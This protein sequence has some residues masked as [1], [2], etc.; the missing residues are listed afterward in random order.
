MFVRSVISE[1][2][3]NN[4]LENLNTRVVNG[5]ETD[6]ELSLPYYKYKKNE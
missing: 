4:E 3:A 1:N 6:Y 5:F 2:K